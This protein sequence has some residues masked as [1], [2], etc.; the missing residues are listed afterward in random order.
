MGP[1]NSS[2][3][4]SEEEVPIHQHPHPSE[5]YTLTQQEHVKEGVY[6][7]WGQATL[8]ALEKYQSAF[9]QPAPY[10]VVFWNLFVNPPGINV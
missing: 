2:T 7:L 5:P 3:S 6:A 4:S 8:E 10:I 9:K 1:L